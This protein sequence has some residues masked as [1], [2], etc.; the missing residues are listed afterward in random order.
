VHPLA[1]AP[2]VAPYFAMILIPGQGKRGD[3]LTAPQVTKSEVAE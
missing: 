3:V 1:E 2:D